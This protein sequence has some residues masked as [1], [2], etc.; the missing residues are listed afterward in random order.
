MCLSTDVIYL[1]TESYLVFMRLCLVLMSVIFLLWSSVLN[2]LILMI[3]DVRYSC[4]LS[5]RWELM[6]VEWLVDNF[7]CA[8]AQVGLH[9]VR[10]RTARSI[11]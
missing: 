10:T 4:D 1:S 6:L 2:L 9:S 7:A 11:V 5:L 3:D 8:I